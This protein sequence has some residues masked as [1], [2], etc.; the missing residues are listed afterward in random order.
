MSTTLGRP[1][2]ADARR[3]RDRVLEAAR[4]VFAEY[5]HEAQMDEIARSAQVGVGTVYR[6]FPTKEALAAAL[7]QDSFR[8]IGERA[9]A[10]LEEPDPWDAFAGVLWH[11]GDLLASNRGL[12]ESLAAQ[13]V[14]A[15][16]EPETDL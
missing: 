6:H 4:R 1:M 10:A 11:G 5:G 2:R 14:D 15:Q 12:T 16:T 9:R 7:L 13:P 8:R 3:N